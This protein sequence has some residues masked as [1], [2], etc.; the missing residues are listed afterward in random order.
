MQQKI[1]VRFAQILVLIS[2]LIMFTLSNVQPAH[3]QTLKPI[4]IN[5]FYSTISSGGIEWVELHNTTNSA[6]NLT[7][8]KLTDLL[9]PTT[10][11]PIEHKT[12]SLSGTLPANGYLAFDLPE[13][14]LQ[15]GGDSIGLYKGSTLI[16]RATYGQITG[17]SP[18][19]GLEVG[20]TATQS[21]FINSAGE[22]EIGSVIT[23]GQANPTTAAA[24]YTFT[25]WGSDGK[26]AGLEDKNADGVMVDSDGN[27]VWDG[28]YF[29]QKEYPHIDLT[30]N[31][32][33]GADYTGNV[34]LVASNV[35]GIQTWGYYPKQ[36]Y[37]LNQVSLTSGVPISWFVGRDVPI[38]IVTPNA[39]TYQ[40]EFDLIGDSGQEIASTAINVNI[41][42]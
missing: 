35:S 20:P 17:Y 8:W 41:T 28:D 24:Q 26:L 9:H 3:A 14:S 33:S 31:K 21:A 11:D 13:A 29:S 38:Y 15:N 25:V 4:I 37:D 7:G 5:E 27:P 30:L 2:A 19:Q 6:I 18:T 1:F 36:W 22:W 10:S 40:I 42:E 16:D 23:K 12:R 34:R 32:T 39:G